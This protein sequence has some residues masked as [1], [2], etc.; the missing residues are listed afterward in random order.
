MG[1]VF[2]LIVVIVVGV[3][4]SLLDPPSHDYKEMIQIPSGPYVYQNE[5]ATMDHSY[6]IDK[7]E[8]TFGMYLKFLR[9][10]AKAGND[11]AWRNPTA[12]CEYQGRADHEPKDWGNIFQ[13]IKRR[14]PYNKVDLNLDMP[15]FNIDW[16]DAEAYAKWAGKRLPDEHEW[17]LAARGKD[18]N[19]YPWGNKFMPYGNN[20]V[21]MSRHGHGYSVPTHMSTKWRSTQ[22]PQDVSPFGVMGMAGNVSEWTDTIVPGSIQNRRRSPSSAARISRP[23][24]ESHAVL[25]YRQQKCARRIPISGSVSVASGDAPP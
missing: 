13:C 8:V 19:L 5:S 17:E 6:Y 12:A 11:S 25:T 23:T 3:L 24:A 1:G 9:A 10:V 14:L 20:S 7:Y 22:M 18:G 4:Y 2:A 21:P 15:V 16:Y